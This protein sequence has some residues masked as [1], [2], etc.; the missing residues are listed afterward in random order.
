MIHKNHDHV[1]WSSDHDSS[2]DQ[3]SCVWKNQEQEKNT[4]KYSNVRRSQKMFFI[5]VKKLTFSQTCLKNVIVLII[6]VQSSWTFKMFNFDVFCRRKIWKNTKA[7][8]MSKSKN[9]NS[10]N[11]Q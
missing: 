9:K 8:K 7:I 10:K 5:C 11:Q 3:L 1:N 4:Q 2:F 6:L